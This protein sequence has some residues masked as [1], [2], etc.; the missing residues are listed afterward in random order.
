[1]H[2]RTITT[3]AA[4]ATG[5]VLTA[6]PVAADTG[7]GAQPPCTITTVAPNATTSNTAA[8]T[9]VLDVIGADSL[10][11]ALIGDALLIH[12]NPSPR[13]ARDA[14]AAEA[15]LEALMDGTTSCACDG[16]VT[17]S[18]STYESSGVD[19]LFTGLTSNTTT[20]A[21]STTTATGTSTSTTGSRSLFDTIGITGLLGSLLDD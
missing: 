5:L 13:D 20:C 4:T 10:L 17:S 11:D 18:T 19:G 8:P 14:I 21:Q 6:A 2:N 16:S 1:M 7:L 12:D 9:S 15:S 3:L